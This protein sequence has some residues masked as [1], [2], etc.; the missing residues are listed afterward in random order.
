MEE[1]AV[2]KIAWRNQWYLFKHSKSYRHDVW[3]FAVNRR[4]GM[5]WDVWDN[6]MEELGL[7][8][9]LYI[10]AKHDMDLMDE[11]KEFFELSDYYF[12]RLEGQLK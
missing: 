10:K 5:D 3:Q 2:K 12:D 6:A 9:A 7:E 4:Y 8:L 11:F 1:K